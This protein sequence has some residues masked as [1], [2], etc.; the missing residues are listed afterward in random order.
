ME[1]LKISVALEDGPQSIIQLQDR[2]RLTCDF[3]G[4][5]CALA[6]EGLVRLDIYDTALGPHT[7]VLGP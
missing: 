6:C 2:T 1:R 5:L 7:I 4:A 3:V